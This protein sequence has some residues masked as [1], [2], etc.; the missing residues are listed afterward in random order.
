[1]TA[2]LTLYQMIIVKET[3]RFFTY[4]ANIY[5]GLFGALFILAARY[6]LWAAL[7]ATGNA[8]DATLSET[9]TYFVVNDCLLIWLAASYG[10]L[11]GGDIR[12]GDI[13]Q[14]LIK[15]CPYHLQLVATSHA[16]AVTATLTRS[17]PILIAALFF[18]GL[19]PPV[20]VAALLFFLLTAIL[21]GA[22]YSL[23]DLCISYSA[24]WLTDY[25]YLSWVRDALFTLFGGIML[26]L[27][28]YPGWLFAVCNFLP[29]KYAVY[30]PVSVYLGRVPVNEI[31]KTFAWQIGWV[32][33]LY[34]LE[35]LIWS[36]AQYKI[37]VQGG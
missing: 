21:G 33:V 34:A 11:I 13:A 25:W 36:R 12:T 4:R 31:G 15:P 10:D 17:V 23:I 7:F 28:F 29:F 22:I 26:P 27:W 6:A 16:N 9:M 1:M 30:Q 20:S 5:A 18:I 2:Y 32:I 19:V 24:F 8:G 35:R 3:Q 14:R 37:T